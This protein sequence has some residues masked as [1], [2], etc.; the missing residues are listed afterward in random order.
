MKL[1]AD[2][3]IHITQKKNGVTIEATDEELVRCYGCEYAID[4]DSGLV[5]TRFTSGMA[6]AD[7]DFCSYGEPRDEEEEAEE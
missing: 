7:Y 6:V 3:I 4:T 2:I 1:P 5:C